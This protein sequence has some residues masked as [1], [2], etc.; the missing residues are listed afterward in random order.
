MKKGGGIFVILQL[1]SFNNN[2]FLKVNLNTFDF[3]KN[4]LT[5]NIHQHSYGESS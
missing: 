1:S 2:N 3:S 5:N 4:S